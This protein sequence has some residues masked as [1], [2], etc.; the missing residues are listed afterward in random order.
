MRKNIVLIVL[1]TAIISI[2]Y[3]SYSYADTKTEY[4]KVATSQSKEE[5]EKEQQRKSNNYLES[6]TIQNY[7]MYPEFNRNNFKYYVSIPSNTSSLEVEA[8]AEIE[9]AKVKITGNNNLSNTENQIKINVTSINGITKTYTIYAT[10]QKENQIKL[11][12]LEIDG[13]VL[14]PEFSENKYFYNVEV[15]QSEVQPLN[16]KAEATVENAKIEIIGNNDLEEGDNTIS[17]L[18]SNDSETTIYQL[19]V[20]IVIKNI[21]ITQSSK[22]FKND[23]INKYNSIKEKVIEFFKDETK[24]LYFLIIVLAI[25]TLIII[26]LLVNLARK[27]KANKNR[28]NIKKRAK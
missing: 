11:K 23:V 24:T 7:E 9:G 16:I 13:T 2:T 17:I 8:K 28:K 6:L 26:L 25:L 4:V 18:V 1:I 21:I 14:E 3:N 19:N 22:N 15:E 5:K 10:K 20:N 12:N 27:R